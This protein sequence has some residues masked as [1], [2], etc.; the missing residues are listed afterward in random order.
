MAF[1]GERVGVALEQA[2]GADPAGE[3]RGVFAKDDH[4]VARHVDAVLER[5]RPIGQAG[6]QFLPR[7]DDHEFERGPRGAQQMGG[8]HRTAEA[9]T[10]HQNGRCVHEPEAAASASIA[11]AKHAC[12]AC[13]TPMPIQP[14]L[15][16]RCA[17][18]V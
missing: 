7:L 4:L 14:P 16:S 8:E 17:T 6:P 10:Q 15:T 11:A 1:C 2:L 9:A 13:A 3:M 18:P 12:G 5:S